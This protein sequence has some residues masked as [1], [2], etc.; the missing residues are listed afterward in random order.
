MEALWSAM[1]VVDYHS[2]VELVVTLVGR[3]ACP[4]S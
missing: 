3:K 4:I 2:S 1:D